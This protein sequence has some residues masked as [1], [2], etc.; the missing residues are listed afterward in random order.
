MIF[1][2]KDWTP[3]QAL[4]ESFASGKGVS[5][6]LAVTQKSIAAHFAKLGVPADKAADAAKSFTQGLSKSLGEGVP[7]G[8]AIAV[9]KSETKV[10]TEAEATEGANANALVQALAKGDNVQAAL[11]NVVGKGAVTKQHVD[12]FI[13]TL[14]NAIAKGVDMA[15]A[16]K[17]AEAGVKAVDTAKGA[18]A[19]TTA[20]AGL[21]SSLAGGT[22]SA[23]ALKTATAGMPP[24][25][26]SAFLKTFQA[27]AA[28]GAD[29]NTALK[30]A[31]QAAAA[32]ADIANAQTVPM[33]AADQIIAALANGGAA[34]LQNGAGLQAM[35]NSLARGGS[36]GDAA[37]AATQATEAQSRQTEAQSVPVSPGQ[38]LMNA[39]ATG[40]DTGTALAGGA[41]F[42]NALT[43][44]LAKGSD[45]ASATQTAQR[46]SDAAQTQTA[47]ASVPLSPAAQLGAA[48]ASGQNAQG[49]INSMAGNFGGDSAAFVANLSSAL[50]KGGDFGAAA[51]QAGSAAQS[52]QQQTSQASQGVTSDP[53]LMAMAS[54]QGVQSLSSFGPSTSPSEAI[55]PV[56]QSAPQLFTSSAPSLTPPAPTPGG[57][58][59]PGTSG[60]GSTNLSPGE[61]VAITFTPPPPQILGTSSN[62]SNNTN[63]TQDTG[64]VNTPPTTPLP[65][66][67][68]SLSVPGTVA[69]YTENGAP[70]SL[71]PLLRVTD[72]DDGALS[73]VQVKFTGWLPTEDEIT[74][75]LPTGM[76][77]TMNSA[78][79][80]LEFS[81]GA[82]LIAYQDVLRSLAYRNLS[83]DPHTTVRKALI[84]VSDGEASAS[85]EFDITVAAVNDAP[86]NSV[87]SGRT[88]DEDNDLVLSGATKLSISDLDDQGQTM[89]V[90]LGVGHGV[91]SLGQTTGLTFT[92]GD[93][94]NDAAMSFSGTKTA[95]NAALASIT[96]RNTLN[97]NGTD[98]LTITTLDGNGDGHSGSGGEKQD[99]DSVAITINPVNDA[100][101]L[102][103]A[104]PSLESLTY[105]Q[106]DTP[107]QRVSTIFQSSIS[108]VDATP[109]QGIAITGTSVPNSYG[110]WQYMIYDAAT[111]T[112]ANF[113]AIGANSAL[114]LRPDDYV[115]FVP[116]GSHTLASGNPA[117]FTYR[118]WD[119]TSGSVG[120]A[121][122]N[123]SATG[124]ITA[125]STA[126]DTAKIVITQPDPPIVVYSG[127]GS[128]ALPYDPGS[129]SV[130]T[131][132]SGTLSPYGSADD[133]YWALNIASAFANG[134]KL[135][136]TTYTNLFAGS[137]G[138]ITFGTGSSSYSPRGIAGSTLPMVAGMYNDID[139]RKGGSI[140]TAVNAT[141]GIVVTYSNV[142]AYN[143]FVSSADTFQIQLKP[144][145]GIAGYAATD[146]QIILR[147]QSI[148]WSQGATGGWTAGVPATK[149]YGEVVGSGTS[150]MT[151]L[152]NTSNVGINGVYSWVVKDGTVLNPIPNMNETDKAV[153]GTVVAALSTA[154][155]ATGATTTYSL[156][157]NPGGMFAI[158]GTNLVLVAGA[159]ID[160]ATN[161][162]HSYDVQVK[163][164]VNGVD[165]DPTTI[166]VTVNQSG[167]T[168][169]AFTGA[170][171]T[172]YTEDT[173]MALVSSVAISNPKVHSYGGGD[174]MVTFDSYATTDRLSVAET[175]GITVAGGT[176]RYNG[177]T[178]GTVDANT[179]N[180][181]GT[182][183]K[184]ALATA[185]NRVS[186][187]AL[188]SA[189][190]YTTA[191]DT[192]TGDLNRAVTV[193]LNDGAGPTPSITGTFTITATNDAPTIAL[194][195]ASTLAEDGV[196]SITGTVGDVD[197]QANDL[198][199]VTL[200]ST[201]GAVT[202]ASTTGLSFTTGDGTSDSSMVF[203][204]TL[205]NLTTALATLNYSPTANYSGTGSV[206]VTVDD[207]GNSGTGGAKT[208][209]ATHSLTITSVN[210]APVLNTSYSPTLSSIDKI[211]TTNPGKLISDII[212]N[213]S[214]T[215]VDVTSGSVPK[216]IAVTGV[217]NSLGQ[218]QYSINGGT[219]W[220]NL[221]SA[222]FNGSNGLLLTATDRLR[223]VPDG[224]TTGNATFTY[225]AWDQ[226]SGNAHDWV[227]LTGTAFSTATETASISI[228]SNT[229]VSDA[230]NADLG[231][232]WLGGSASIGGGVLH[233]NVNATDQ[234]GSAIFKSGLSTAQGFKVTFDYWVGGGTNVNH[235]RTADGFAL[236]MLNGTASGPTLGG[237]G[238][239]LGFAGMLS[240]DVHSMSNLLMGVGFDEYGNFTNSNAGLSWGGP[241]TETT[242]NIV[243]M[244]VG[245]AVTGNDHT[246]YVSGSAV[247]VAGWNVGLV[248]SRKVEFT[249][250]ANKTFNL[251]M[252]FDGG[253]TW[254]DLWSN[255]QYT[256]LADAIGDTVS[257]GFSGAT[258]GATNNHEIDNVVVTVL[259]PVTTTDLSA[260]ISGPATANLGDALTL[261]A[262]VTNSGS[263]TD[264]SAHFVYTA[265]NGFT[266]NNWSYTTNGGG[267]GSGTGGIDTTLKLSPN[268]VATFSINGT[269]SAS[270]S[271]LAQTASVTASIGDS[272]TAN[273][274]ATASTTL[275][276]PINLPNQY[277]TH[278]SG[279]SGLSFN[280]GATGLSSMAANYTVETWVKITGSTANW[281]G[282]V[283]FMDQPG[284]NGL[285]VLV[286]P[287]GQVRLD[288]TGG[289]GHASLDS[290]ISVAD[291][292]WH[293]IAA[294]YDNNQMTMY[295]DGVADTSATP[296]AGKFNLPTSNLILGND[297]DPSYTGQRFLNGDL[298]GVNVWNTARSSQEIQADMTHKTLGTESGLLASFHLDETSNSL[299][300][301]TGKN[302]SAGRSSGITA[303]DWDDFSVAHGSS[304]KSMV[305]GTTSTNDS[306]SYALHNDGVHPNGGAQ[307][308]SVS[309]SGETFTYTAGGTAHSDSFVIDISD[310]HGHTTAHTIH[311][312]VT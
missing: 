127:I 103:A 142:H 100:P 111:P 254:L 78:T 215:D 129:K 82:S 48:L 30:A 106:T 172:A 131:G 44:A 217:D 198:I 38:A 117:T 179:L 1:D 23:N 140:T 237:G 207:Q 201:N 262:T 208:A 163:A 161:A 291:G 69:A 220:T 300:D 223:F 41:E 97:Y 28:S 109:S 55:A 113:P 231:S 263:V 168:T 225:K 130:L 243:A 137:N 265:P 148:N 39:L 258:G 143:I 146:F 133:T 13:N 253:G 60:S 204:G 264:P 115:R 11:A 86:V 250:N 232:W 72:S 206:S 296:G 202:L 158:S 205:A 175:G 80:L 56:G 283:N 156:V 280:N 209:T 124:G 54:G 35:L 70:L 123:M 267:S 94:T 22:D 289:G 147:Y 10:S 77:A 199:K 221:L 136:S 294:T 304:Y 2:L 33:S 9:V 281:V 21:M 145:S 153:G 73:L 110:T 125:F 68:P 96:Y 99:Q 211:A 104:A 31:G 177:T 308:G 155:A 91:V 260:S 32:Q 285:K 102:T 224:A 171:G 189:L 71:Q 214:I 288:T 276:L 46:A 43:Q 144:L 132:L 228:S 249:M 6:A 290:S 116:D 29:T 186:V 246:P 26:A 256:Q 12:A 50:A 120:Y 84:T 312:T 88:V 176:I 24:D 20:A 244:R 183:L 138:Y 59:G 149:N 307:Y 159:D 18:Q 192:P 92:A 268:E 126:T 154:R 121:A 65:N 247:N 63:N 134:L 67:A 191:S 275:N 178:I 181:Q 274:T 310:Q 87:S 83:D 98:T 15:T 278:F 51:Q 301:A 239:L 174:L 230:F 173:P 47:S 3:P 122:N 62:T 213:G 229:L 128:N 75:T 222:S 112:W 61:T 8:Q 210:D 282:L 167:N 79:G 240:S 261:T 169:L 284:G 299:A 303:N 226:T 305:L 52:S 157:S 95:L 272:N 293:F 108:E 311:V 141:D 292:K 165:T 238:P 135:G 37:K 218:W 90:S 5:E 277:S 302:G 164:T 271:S 101:V 151:N 14:Q 273:N 118:A 195:A 252:S 49:A 203:T 64:P 40:K 233:L 152:E 295:I 107:G 309:L 160:F 200:S 255:F 114:L 259:N 248:G 298:A 74:Y 279:V 25:Q 162:S 170:A 45:I 269:A 270:W 216:S 190:R 57:A 58:T 287:S 66:Q 187:E 193:T 306:L 185:A 196:L 235:P 4:L 212:P 184:I 34:G 242:P 27:A 180:G 76:T 93:G 297:T 234:K 286:G 219:S 16:L 236:V 105:S 7:P 245:N 85:A 119:Q 17:Q 197:A 241:F 227:S 81:G 150:S 266:V 194:S 19:P 166:S 182:G 42:A 89:K 36:S 139:T 188:V 53:T 251:K 257:L